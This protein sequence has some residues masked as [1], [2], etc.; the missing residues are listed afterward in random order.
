MKHLVLIPVFFV[1]I[2]TGCS[3]KVVPSAPKPPLIVKEVFTQKEIPGQPD[4][5]IRDYIKMTLEFEVE[6]DFMINELIFRGK[7][8][9]TNSSQRVYKIDIAAGSPYTKEV[10]IKDNEAIL[11]YTY[12]GNNQVMTLRNIETKEPIYLP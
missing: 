1:L 10:S 4:G 3:P 8:Y 11:F 12:K 6:R 7:S 5:L 9:I 2:C